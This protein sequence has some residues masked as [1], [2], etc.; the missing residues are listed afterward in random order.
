MP[1]QKFAASPWTLWGLTAHIDSQVKYLCAA[2]N[3][4]NSW[5]STL[6]APEAGAAVLCAPSSSL[7]FSETVGSTFAT[8]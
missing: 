2:P 7:P 3:Q 4:A 5:R 1:R 6:H 8:A